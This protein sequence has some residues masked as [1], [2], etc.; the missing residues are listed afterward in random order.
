LPKGSLSPQVRELA[1][2]I[3]TTLPPVFA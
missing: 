1:G 2:S 3:I